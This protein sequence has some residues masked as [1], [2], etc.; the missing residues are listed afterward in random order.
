MSGECL[1]VWQQ[2]CGCSYMYVCM[3]VDCKS[4]SYTDACVYSNSIVGVPACVYACVLFVRGFMYE[5]FIH[6]CLSVWQRDR[7]G[8]CVCAC[9]YVRVH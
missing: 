1:G 5:C 4:D 7:G 3:C 6:E 2:G 8:S 9:V